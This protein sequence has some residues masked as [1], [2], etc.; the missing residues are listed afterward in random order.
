MRQG[1]QSSVLALAALAAMGAD[2]ASAARLGA[3]C[4]REGAD[5]VCDL[6][7]DEAVAIQSVTATV[8]GQA[9]TSELKPFDPAQQSTGWYFLVQQNAHPQDSARAIERMIKFDGK[10]SYG[11]ASFTEKI[12]ERA[13]LGAPEADIKRL[14]DTL[15][16]LRTT[17]R[18]NLYFS[19]NEALAKLNEAKADR[20]ALV[21]FVDGNSITE[22]FRDKLV[23]AV[24]ESNTL[25]IGIVV[26]RNG[27]PVSVRSLVDDTRGI[28]Y[29]AI[30]CTRP[31]QQPVRCTD[32][33]VA[34]AFAQSFLGLL[35][36]G[37][38]LRIPGTSIPAGSELTLRATF[39]DGTTSTVER[40]AAKSTGPTVSTPEPPP[41]TDTAT[42]PA[43]AQQQPEA[44]VPAAP[45]ARSELQTLSM[46]LFK[47]YVPDSISKHI[48]VWAQ[49]NIILIAAALM[50]TLG[51]LLLLV[52]I[53][54][55]RKTAALAAAAAV[56]PPAPTSTPPRRAAPAGSR[57]ITVRGGDP[58]SAPPPPRPAKPDQPMPETKIVTATPA[59]PE[60]KQVLAWVQ[61]L[62]AKST[63]V[64]IIS[65][66]VRIGRHVDN[67]ITLENRTV[68]RHHAVLH[69]SVDGVFT[70]TDLDTRNRVYVNREAIQSRELADGD[71]VELGEVRFRFLEN[72][73]AAVP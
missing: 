31:G 25:L 10:R 6:R 20:K 43:P 39:A 52:G 44:A 37:G 45:A 1:W 63:R 9:V 33:D 23:R 42:T 26:G 73:V 8:R 24:N 7:A 47:N 19:A 16:V 13:P 21:L 50:F 28:Y 58:D 59:I 12:E 67:D 60:P 22:D 34:D 3:S 2:P 71:L 51:L 17:N 27:R 72:R 30:P 40:I 32:F 29:E 11:V 18:T 4:G 15:V 41:A 64:P 5:V 69:R 68:H 66:S 65:A 55:S 35:E 46:A 70:I 57:P 54:R 61:F 14:K 62:D 38:T 49:E 36:N 56:P 48:P 53:L